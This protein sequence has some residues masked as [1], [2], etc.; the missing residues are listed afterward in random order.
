MVLSKFVVRSLRHLAEGNPTVGRLRAKT[1]WEEAMG[2]R[3]KRLR[4]AAGMSQSAL[5]KACGIPL[6]SYQQWEQGRRTPLLDAAARVAQALGVSL[7]E[8]AG[9]EP[10]KGK[11]GGK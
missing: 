6:R 11:K 5:A 2:K 3:F 4:E 7:D 1:E 8:L 10:P 9:I